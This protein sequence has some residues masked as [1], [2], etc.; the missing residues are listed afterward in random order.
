[1][2]NGGGSVSKCLVECSAKQAILHG[3]IV[4]KTRAVNKPLG[5]NHSSYSDYDYAD[6]VTKL[7]YK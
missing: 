6:K 4:M 5:Y 2:L 1:M 3:L 7:C